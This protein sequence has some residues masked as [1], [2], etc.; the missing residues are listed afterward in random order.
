[1]FGSIQPAALQRAGRAVNVFL[2]TL[3]RDARLIEQ[4]H[5]VIGRALVVGARIGVILD[6][7]IGARFQPE[8][9]RLAGMQAGRI[10]ILLRI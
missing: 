7:K 3:P 2:V 9:V 6:A 8:I 4:R 10:I 1:M 5:E